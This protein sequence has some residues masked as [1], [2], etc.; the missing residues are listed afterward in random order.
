[1]APNVFVYIVLQAYV[2]CQPSAEK[3][4]VWFMTEKTLQGIKRSVETCIEL[5]TCYCVSHGGTLLE[6]SAVLGIRSTIFG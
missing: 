5:L 3:G 2:F 1:M 4:E 6:Y